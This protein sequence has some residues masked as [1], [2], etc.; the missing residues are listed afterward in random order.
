MPRADPDQASDAA[1]QVDMGRSA[2]LLRL[3]P[4][5]AVAWVTLTGLLAL[6]GWA[7]GVRLLTGIA[8]GRPAL[9]PAT[10]V[11][12]ILAGAT[13]WLLLPGRAGSTRRLGRAVA[14]LVAGLGAVVL[15]EYL[16]GHGLG[17]DR[18]LFAG[19]LQ[20]SGAPLP[21]RPSPHTAVAFLLAGSALALLDTDRRGGYRPTQVLAP[22]S[23]TVA[24]IALLGHLYRVDYLVGN[25]NQTNGM[26]VHTAVALV[27]LNAGLLL[28]RPDRGV[29]RAFTNPGPG[30]LLARRLLPAALLTP[31]VAG[32]LAD[33][34][35]RAGW[36]DV[37][38]RLALTV[39]TT[40]ACLLAVVGLTVRAIDQAVLARRHA[41]ERLHASQH[42][43]RMLARNLPNGA[44]FLFDHD[45]RYLVA[46]GAGLAAVG[47][48]AELLEG[49]TIWQALP[50]DTCA[51]I[52]PLYRAA[53]AGQPR[54]QDIPFGGYL[55]RVH[56]LP[57]HGPDGQVEAGM[58]LSQDIT[59]QRQATERLRA[60][61]AQF[62]GLLE[63]A[64]DAMVIVDPN[65]RITLVNQQ[66]EQLFGY[67][68]AE[69]LGQPVET[70]VPERF[71]TEHRQHRRGYLAAP[72][73]RPMG[74]GLG[75]ALFGRRKD[76]SE[77]PVEISLSPLQTSQGTLVSAAVRDITDRKH[78][79]AALQQAKLAAEQ[80]NQAKSD[81]LSRMSHELRTPLNAILGFAQLLELD[82]FRPE[83]R[84]SLRHILSGANHLLGLINEVL[85]IAAIEAGRLS[86]SLE[87]VLV[88]DVVAET[89]SLIRPL[90]DQREILLTNPGQGCDD[91]V[92]GDRQR[93]KQILLNLLSNAVKYNHQGGSVH[94]TC[95]PVAGERLRLSV[96]DTG[97]GIAVEQLELLFVPF[98]RLGSEQSG[99][100]GS[101]LGLPLSKRLAE[102]MSGT[103]E[104]ATTPGQGSTFWVELPL[105]EGPVERAERERLEP[106]PA[107]EQPT[108]AGPTLTV[109]CIEDNLSNLQLVERVLGH[110]PGVRLISAMRPQLGLDLAN[111]HQPDLVLLDLHLPDMPGEEVLH[112][113]RAHPR[114]ADVPVVILTADARPSLVTRL[115]EQGARAFLTK[116]LDVRELLTLL[117]AVAAERQRA[118][119]PS[120]RS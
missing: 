19:S 36:Y 41:E 70:L 71:H 11:G 9:A 4:Q 107:Q 18:L 20:H 45:L 47:L 24:L 68:P 13:L 91:H 39:T 23:A 85:D 88:A 94:L 27:A 69:L 32:L 57:L 75:L 21:G 115:L 58:A 106:P 117:D 105:V 97:P 110:R 30:G 101:G 34:G 67:T 89:V 42:R 90:A 17:V 79:Q 25:S 102:A 84:D 63:A 120:P 28:A 119:L 86:L 10:A 33:A 112:H 22:L 114:T 66:T 62:R 77:F 109:L 92:L 81:Y 78:A 15:A 56:L 54:E 37:N 74:M 116:P 118:G 53:L 87:P 38:F 44:V 103:L 3:I 49:K 59:L 14:V 12:L 100:E 104:V 8:P 80:A 5:V 76:G 99:V 48:S 43:Y 96:T 73:M 1:D 93:L 111:Q 2:A 26:A 40:M 95:E 50:A 72:T 82:E 16:T 65:G 98:E 52:E 46:D 51:V 29:V 31:P 60:S 83:Q 61:E 6:A 35:H 55:Y 108:S 113:L 64:P 7:L